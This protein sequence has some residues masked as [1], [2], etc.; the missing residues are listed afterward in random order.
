MSYTTEDIASS[1][2]IF[3]YLLEHHEL[4]STDDAA[5][6]KAFT[7]SEEVQVLV[8]SQAEIADVTIDRYEDVIYLIPGMENYFL[9]FSKAELRQQ[10]CRSNNSEEDYF[11]ALFAIMVLILKFYDGYGNSA[12]IRD[13][14][15]F[16]ELQ[17]NISEYLKKGV[18]RY[19][20]D[21]QNASGLLFS[22]MYHSYESLRSE[23]KVSRKKTTKEGFLYTIIRF[24]QD[25][26]LVV[27][28]EQDEM[29]KTT[30]KFDHFMDWNLLDKNNY[31]KI[32][33]MM[34]DLQDE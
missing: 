33:N 32:V 21:E 31:E 15:K 30:R 10:L 6:Y 17:N 9:G 25:Q 14:I 19:S 28:I 3:Y 18:N 1:Q 12:K 34:K 24:L 29:I 16:G 20:E 8:R 27:Y 4:K 7:D 11:L 26:G 22:N 5:L 2:G 23:E 13:Y